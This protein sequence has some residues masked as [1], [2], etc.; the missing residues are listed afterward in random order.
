CLDFFHSCEFDI[1]W[2]SRATARVGYAYW[3]RLLVYAKAGA[4]IAR[5]QAQLGCNTDSQPTTVPLYG[6]PYQTDSKT[7]APWTLG[8][9]SE[10]GLTQNVS[11]KS[12]FM[13]FDL[14]TDRFNLG[15]IPVDIGRSGFSS[16]VG[17][18]YRFGG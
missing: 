17:L 5:E 7:K 6:C 4:V 13:Y 14:G 18:H 1:D 9:G 11:V 8:W 2:L 10:F 16:T 15:G 12:E 3:D